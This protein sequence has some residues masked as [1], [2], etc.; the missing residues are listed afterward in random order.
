MTRGVKAPVDVNPETGRRQLF[1]IAVKFGLTAADMQ[2]VSEQLE[3]VNE[4]IAQWHA[5]ETTTLEEFL[6]HRNGESLMDLAERAS[7]VAWEQMAI[8]FGQQFPGYYASLE[9]GQVRVREGNV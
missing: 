4:L 8:A 9:R 5:L 1:S 7:S 3:A 6:A 2:A